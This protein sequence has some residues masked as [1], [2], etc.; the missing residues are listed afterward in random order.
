MYPPAGLG[1][2][3]VRN[4]FRARDSPPA[5]RLLL[6]D[7]QFV[8][9]CLPIR[10]FLRFRGGGSEHSPSHPDGPAAHTVL[11]EQRAARITA[12]RRHR[13]PPTASEQADFRQRRMRGR[14][15]GEYMSAASAY[16]A[17]EMRARQV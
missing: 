8:R 16:T 10:C 7:A 15:L 14:E 2:S 4:T 5:L 11:A 13:P 9:T 1:R 3:L 6:L 17:D 12:A